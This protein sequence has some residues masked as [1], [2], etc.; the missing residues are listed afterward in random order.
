[1]GPTFDRSLVFLYEGDI[2]TQRRTQREDGLG[3]GRWGWNDAARVEDCWQPTGAR[4][5]KE[6]I[7]PES[8]QREYGPALISD[9]SLWNCERISFY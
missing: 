6:R 3:R 5:R 9:S 2:W 7:L 1:M 4:V 8:L